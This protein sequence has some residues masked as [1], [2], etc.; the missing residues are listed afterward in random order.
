MFSVVAVSGILLFVFLM[1]FQKLEPV[2]LSVGHVVGIE[3][4]TDSCVTLT[5]GQVP[6][7]R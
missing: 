5:C 7:L 6:Q 3:V 2:F 1:E 4:E